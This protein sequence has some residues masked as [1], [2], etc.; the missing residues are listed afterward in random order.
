MPVIYNGKQSQLEYYAL[1]G[2]VS[3][4]GGLGRPVLTIQTTLK[5]ADSF[6]NP[7]LNG[8]NSAVQYGVKHTNALADKTTPER[9]KGTGSGVN[10]NDTS[11]GYMARNNYTGGD[12]FDINGQ[13]KT[14]APATG[15][16]VGRN[17]TVTLNISTWGYGPDIS[18]GGANTNWY[19]HPDTTGNVGQVD[20]K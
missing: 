2:N 15:A 10:L 6:K 18:N 9:G 19:K 13:D 3:V 20:I 8:K 14:Q 12:D 1:N 4:N 7:E 11:I 17:K 16:G 5:Y